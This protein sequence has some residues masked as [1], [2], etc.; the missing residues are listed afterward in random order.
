MSNLNK[1]DLVSITEDGVLFWN[2][3][4]YVETI[5][6]GGTVSKLTCTLCNITF[7]N[8]ILFNRHP[9]TIRHK[10][11][12][13]HEDDTNIYIKSIKNNI[14]PP[15][16]L[17]PVV[18]NTHSRSYESKIYRIGFDKFN[19]DRI[20]TN[21]LNNMRWYVNCGPAMSKIS[22][23]YEYFDIDFGILEI[24]VTGNKRYFEKVDLIIKEL[25]NK[26]IKK[27]IF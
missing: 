13:I 23:E 14:T 25:K 21:L 17:N 20:T 6:T 27:M 7:T 1:K 10:N 18:I 4:L 3:N 16:D 22:Y 2:E 19:F 15:P 5:T 12:L 8:E 9:Q 26:R 11:A 24:N